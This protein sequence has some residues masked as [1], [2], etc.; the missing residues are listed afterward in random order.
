MVQTGPTALAEEAVLRVR[1]RQLQVFF[2]IRCQRQVFHDRQIRLQLIECGDAWDRGVDVLV[3][4]NPFE[5]CL[6]I[7]HGFL[8]PGHPRL[9]GNGLHGHNAHP[10][11]GRVSDSFFS[12][13]NIFDQ[14]IV[15]DHGHIIKAAVRSCA[16]S[17][18]DETV[19][20]YA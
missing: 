18:R 16:E 1:L 13:L 2:F 11:V 15:S 9:T 10:F 12:F 4:Q 8:F 6:G 19:R 20:T 14:E 3:L 7:A 17:F 5:G